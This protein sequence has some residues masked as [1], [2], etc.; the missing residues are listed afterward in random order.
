MTRYTFQI[1]A[2]PANNTK[3][4][5]KQT[6]NNRSVSH[7]IHVTRS[8][9]ASIPHCSNFCK[10]K[11]KNKGTWSIITKKN[12]FGR[13]TIVM[14]GQL[15]TSKLRLIIYL[16]FQ[17]HKMLVPFLLKSSLM[18]KKPIRKAK[19]LQVIKPNLYQIQAYLGAV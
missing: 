19:L 16:S 4:I 8:S 3:E 18:H 5:A 2:V 14:F 15:N 12:C 11:S 17:A 9:H 6:K 1:D 7:T 10:T 13:P